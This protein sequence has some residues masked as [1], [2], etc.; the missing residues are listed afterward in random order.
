[1]VSSCLNDAFPDKTA[2]QTG[3]GNTATLS[4]PEQVNLRQ[5]SYRE[6]GVKS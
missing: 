4:L 2:F 5:V 3:G 1:M 6:I